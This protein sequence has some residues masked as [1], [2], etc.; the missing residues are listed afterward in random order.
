MRKYI[1]ALPFLL[2]ILGC[3]PSANDIGRQ[4]KEDSFENKQKKQ[5]ELLRRQQEVI[6]RQH[7][8]LMDLER[9]QYYDDKYREFHPHE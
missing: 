8:E 3:Y 2:C 1:V 4:P 7:D 9:Q 6:K 5:E